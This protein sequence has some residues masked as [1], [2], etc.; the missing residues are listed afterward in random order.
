MANLKR[1]K[2]NVCK[3]CVT[4]LNTHFTLGGN[5]A[6]AIFS[7]EN[8]ESA[9]KRSRAPARRRAGSR[10]RGEGRA[11]RAR[12]RSR[13][14]SRR[15]RRRNTATTIPPPFPYALGSLKNISFRILTK[16]VKADLRSGDNSEHLLQC[17]HQ[18]RCGSPNRGGRFHVWSEKGF[19]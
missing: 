3:R 13:E 12:S 4:I 8:L 14:G 5:V 10:A 17:H 16:N 2:S 19:F 18:L 11:A 7:V 1:L 6:A 9:G 15:A